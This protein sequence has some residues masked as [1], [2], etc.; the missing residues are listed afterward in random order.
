MAERAIGGRGQ[1]VCT[2]E[3]G[4]YWWCVCGR[5]KDQPF[6]DGSHE[7]PPHTGFEPTEFVISQTQRCALCT[8]KRTHNP[9]MC[10]GSHKSLPPED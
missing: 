10:D 2:L 4:T 6:C 1:I 8:C 5:S 7:G 9:P 3:P